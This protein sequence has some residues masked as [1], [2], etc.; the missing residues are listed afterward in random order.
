MRRQ[1]NTSG[2]PHPTQCD[3]PPCYEEAIKFPSVSS[4]ITTTTNYASNDRVDTPA[5]NN[6]AQ[7][8]ELLPSAFAIAPSTSHVLLAISLQTTCAQTQTRL[9]R[10]ASLNDLEIFRKKV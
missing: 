9:Q 3:P 8:H 5:T 6:S 7:S 1:I 2:S 4:V 10:S